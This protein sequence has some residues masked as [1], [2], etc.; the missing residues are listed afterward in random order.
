MKLIPLERNTTQTLL[1]IRF[2]DR[3]T[4]RV[5]DDGLQV[6]AQRLSDDRTQR[7]GKIVVGKPTPSG[8]I[9]FFGLA[10]EET[11]ASS[12]PQL[13][14]SE[15]AKQLVSIDLVDRLSRFLPVSFVAQLPFRGVFCGQEDWPKPPRL[16]PEGSPIQSIGVQLWSSPTRP[17][18]P[19]QAVIRAQVVVGGGVNAPPA[20]YA[21]VRVQRS[22]LEDGFDHYGMTDERGTLLLPMPY[23]AIPDPPIGDPYPSLDRQIFPLSVTIQYEANPSVLP[24]SDVPSLENLLTQSSSNIAIHRVDES[25][26]EFRNNLPVALRF[27]RSLIL[28]TAVSPGS[29]EVES[30]LRIQSA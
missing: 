11:P 5:I 24:S 22:L 21:L 16:N 29:A 3:V 17:V 25:T 12:D 15:P 26:L 9:A 2:W 10:S 4:N 1:G 7:L 20:A 14:D 28:G 23:P 8:V 27:G 18:P 6:T 13:W 19:G 30:V